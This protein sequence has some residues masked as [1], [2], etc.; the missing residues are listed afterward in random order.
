MSS[1]NTAEKN[2]MERLRH[3]YR[4]VVMNNETF[5]E[6]G[7]YRLS[8]LN[9][10]ILIS[11]IVVLVALFVLGIIIFTP[12]KRYIPGYGDASEIKELIRLNEQ[13]ATME[14][15][16]SAQQAYTSN[17]RRILVGD[18]ETNDEQQLGSPELPEDSLL[19]VERIKEDEL[20]RKEIELDQQIQ[21]RA[22]REK[23]ANFSP[24]DIPLTQLYLIPPVSGVVSDDFDMGEQHLGIDIMAPKDT[25]IKAV[26]DGYVISA[27][28]TLETGHSIGVQHNNNL[29]SFYKHNSALLKEPGDYVEAGEALAIIGNT[30]KLSNGQHL[31]FE[32]W[33][34]GKALDPADFI[35]FE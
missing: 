3:T 20:L 26:A 33:H 25:P 6:V 2:L 12:A 31:H 35:I 29:I 14:E 13:I 28:W 5:E 22:L 1:E 7:S 10:Y 34:K 4:L 11:T 8:L 9:V 18:I 23:T 32:L 17:F 21:E 24:R 16:L 30:G 15:Q 19:H 27:D